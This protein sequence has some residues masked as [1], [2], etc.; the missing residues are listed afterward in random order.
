MGIYDP[1]GFPIPMLFPTYNSQQWAE[2]IKALES[3]DKPLLH[4][5]QS[6][7]VPLLFTIHDILLS[8]PQDLAVLANWVKGHESYPTD[9]TIYNW[10]KTTWAG[11]TPFTKEVKPSLLRWAEHVLGTMYRMDGIEPTN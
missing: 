2:A 1:Q 8:S 6:S 7:L 9:L 11:H 10:T 4:L 3:N 5:H